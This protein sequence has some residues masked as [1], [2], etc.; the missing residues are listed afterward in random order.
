MLQIKPDRD[1]T[2][3]F[4]GV[5]QSAVL[6]Y[7]LAKLDGYDEEALHHSAY[8]L[9]RLDAETTEV[10]FGSIQGVNLGLRTV[11]RLFS[12]KPD[13]STGDVFRYAVGMHRLSMKLQHWGKTNEIVRNRLVE[14]REKYLHID[15]NSEEGNSKEDNSGPDDALF[16]ELAG[17]YT[18]TISYLTPRIMVQGAQGKLENPQ[19][20]HR[21]RTALFAGIRSAFLWRQLGGRRWQLFFNRKDYRKTASQLLSV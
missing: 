14:I 16:E 9:L 21:V 6:V 20:V 15:D 2:L 5:F 8:S 11:V 18:E 4:S 7:Q 12:D 13:A 17:L 10:V 1:L 3:A 19:T